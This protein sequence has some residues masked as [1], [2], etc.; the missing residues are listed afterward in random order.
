METLAAASCDNGACAIGCLVGCL[1]SGEATVAF[2]ALGGVI[3]SWLVGP[4]EIAA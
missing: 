4:A 1:V 3:G 2:G